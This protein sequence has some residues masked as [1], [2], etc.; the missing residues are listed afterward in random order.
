MDDSSRQIIIAANWKMYKNKSQAEDFCQEF[1]AAAPQNS[2]REAVIIPPS[3]LIGTVSQALQG[4]GAKVGIQNIHWEKEGAYT[5]E[6]SPLMAA[7]S[8]CEYCLCGHSERRHYFEETSEMITWKAQSAR[9][10]G[11]RPIICLGET[12]EERDDGRTKEILR[13]ELLAV[14]SGILN[15]DTDIVLAYEPVW[16]IGTGVVASPSDA[17]DAIAYIRSVIKEIWG[18]LA[19]KISILYGGS[20]KPDNIRQLMACPDI[21]GVLVGGASLNPD[22][23]AKIYNY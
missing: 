9:Y 19:D 5:G 12:L 18:G 4:T 8:G 11:I 17:K 16:A 1:A 15:P 2:Q 6:V 13:S 7:D 22:S 10:W 21:D 20:V 23:F 3:I 14:L